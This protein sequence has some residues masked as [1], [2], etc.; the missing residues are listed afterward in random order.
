LRSRLTTLSSL[1]PSAA[2]TNY[3]FFI[4]VFSGTSVAL[5]QA[6]QRNAVPVDQD[7]A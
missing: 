5:S 3:F 1:L 7:I 4:V 2:V 6:R